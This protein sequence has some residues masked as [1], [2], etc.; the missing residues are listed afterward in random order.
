MSEYE[1]DPGSETTESF[2]DVFDALQLA[3]WGED[4]EQCAPEDL[5]IIAGTSEQISNCRI[6]SKVALGKNLDF[7]AVIKHYGYD[8]T[9]G[10]VVSHRENL[11]ILY[12][13]TKGT[14]IVFDMT[15]LGIDFYESMD[16]E[17]STAVIDEFRLV[18]VP[19]VKFIKRMAKT[20]LIAAS[21][22]E[23]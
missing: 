23:V 6:R 15:E 19:D 21:A 18:D 14:L 7:P 22:S 20:A 11:D 1:K 5:P 9:I 16:I 8:V 13:D 2:Q 3:F 12:L 10:G 17:R 4:F